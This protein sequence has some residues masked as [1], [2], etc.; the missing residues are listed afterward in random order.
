MNLRSLAAKE[1]MKGRSRLNDRIQWLY[2]ERTNPLKYQTFFLG[3]TEYSYFLH[4]YNH[5]W[6]NERAVEVPVAVRLLNSDKNATVLEVG[7]VLSHYFNLRHIVLDK[8]ERSWLRPV[9]NQDLLEY[10]PM[11]R[12]DQIVS[13]STIEHVGWDE[14]PRIEEAVL[15]GFRKVRSLLAPGG[16][17]LITVPVG[18]NT[19]LD[20]HVPDLIDHK[21]TLRCLKRI[22][23]DNQWEEV[24][25]RDALSCKYGAP[26]N[27]ANAVVFVSLKE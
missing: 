23:K 6:S 21:T 20:R 10:K 12:F 14:T 24:D 17:A 5:T 7:N 18:Y 16:R 4:P 8:Y 22:A 26:Y 19:Y 9:V 27:N 2:H 25:L 3:N 15:S 1:Y 13:I 11:Q